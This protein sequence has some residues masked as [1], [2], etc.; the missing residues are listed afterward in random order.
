MHPACPDAS[1]DN[2]TTRLRVQQKHPLLATQTPSKH[3]STYTQSNSTKWLAEK[4]RD[5]ARSALQ[6]VG[7]ASDATFLTGKTGGK[8]GGKAG[9]DSGKT[10]KSHSAKAGLQVRT[11]HGFKQGG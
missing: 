5:A 11:R 6:A 10:Q 7:P 3:T 8:T 1:F 4:V 2:T 9:G